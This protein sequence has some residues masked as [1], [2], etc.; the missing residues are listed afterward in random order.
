MNCINHSYVLTYISTATFSTP[1]VNNVRQN[2]IDS[3]AAS[4]ALST[5]TGGFVRLLCG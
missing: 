5:D 3:V 1:G 2:H 4:G